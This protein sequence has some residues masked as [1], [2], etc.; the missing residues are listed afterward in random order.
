MINSVNELRAKLE[1]HGYFAD[2]SL[3]TAIYLATKLGRPLFLEG[4]PGVGKT[5]VAKLLAEFINFALSVYSAILAWKV[6]KSCMN[7]I[8]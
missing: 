1:Q 5:E 4:E 2:D 6:A 7:G 3:L 8:T